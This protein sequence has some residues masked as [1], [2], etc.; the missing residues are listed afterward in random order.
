MAVSHVFFFAKSYRC[1]DCGG[2][3]GVRSRKRT[4]SERYIAPLFLVQPVRCAACYRRDYWSI[5]T[6]VSERVFKEIK[7]NN[8]G[9]RDAA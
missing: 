4:F 9:Q 3:V 2:K 7:T 6:P 1:P 8:P 5:F